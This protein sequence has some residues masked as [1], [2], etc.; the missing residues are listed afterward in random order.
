V[1]CDALLASIDEARQAHAN[2]DPA[3]ELSALDR[4]GRPLSAWREALA[5]LLEGTRAYREEPID[6]RTLVRVLAD[7]DV[8]AERRIAAAIALAPQ[9][10]DTAERIREA[11]AASASEP[12]RVAL[13]RAADGT[14]DDETVDQA[15]THERTARR[16]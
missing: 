4:A 16:L 8:P 3:P 12:L 10:G 9:G 13:E 6:R 2:R 1:R 14:I 15:V 7:V 11:A 5:S